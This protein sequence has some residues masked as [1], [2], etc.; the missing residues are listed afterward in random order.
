MGGR[1]DEAKGTQYYTLT[2]GLGWMLHCNAVN[3]DW[4]QWAEEAQWQTL[5]FGVAPLLV[6]KLVSVT[7]GIE[8]AKARDARDA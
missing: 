6:R 2:E 5:Y 8:R 1:Q 3:D 4:D 7:L